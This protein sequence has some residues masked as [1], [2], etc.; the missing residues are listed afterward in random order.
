[1]FGGDEDESPL[2]FVG[3]LA[4]IL[5]APIAAMVLQL[6]VSCQREHLADTTAATLLG[7]ARPLA[8]ALE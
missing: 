7:E 6:S 8:Y 4:A 3:T 1:M 5:I 2:G